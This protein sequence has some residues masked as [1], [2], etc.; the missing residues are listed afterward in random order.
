M[1]LM[2]MGHPHCCRFVNQYLLALLTEF[3]S[4]ANFAR[5]PPIP[6]TLSSPRVSSCVPHAHQCSWDLPQ[7]F[8]TSSVSNLRRSVPWDIEEVP[9][10][11]EL[12]SPA[13]KSHIL[14]NHHSHH[15]QCHHPAQDRGGNHD[16]QIYARGHRKPVNRVT[17]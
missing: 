1:I 9:S 8:L 5:Q 13:P 11:L 4:F 12:A 14:R 2:N 16:D 10:F 17:V 6:A 15:Q 7:I 3:C